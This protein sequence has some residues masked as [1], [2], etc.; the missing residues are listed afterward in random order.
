MP[1]WPHSPTHRLS[2]AGAY[3]ITGGTYRKQAFF[4]SRERLKFL[5]ETLLD[6][7]ADYK[8]QLEAWAV[9]PN[10]YHFV[11]TSPARIADLRRF[12]GNLHTMTAKEVNWLDRTPERKVWF[13][14]WDSHITYQKSYLARLNY[15]HSNAVKHGLVRR[16]EQYE[17]CSAGWFQRTAERSFC[18]TV[19][20][21]RSEGIRIRDDFSVNSAEIE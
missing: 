9:F 4:G 20:R 15:V 21:I 19:M 6:L 18:E 11:A 2:A 17:W 7:A 1:D 10:H 5:C 13:Q 16:P 8:L 3:M 12:I 14:Y